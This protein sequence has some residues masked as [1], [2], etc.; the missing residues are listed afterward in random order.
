MYK[1]D[2]AINQITVAQELE[3]EGLLEKCGGAAY[4]SRLISI[5]P[6]SLDIEHYARIVYRLS[7]MR[8]LISAADKIS[9]IGYE[10]DPDVS[11]ALN[12][13]EDTLFRLRHERSLDFVHIKNV[14]D[15]YFEAPN[16]PGTAGFQAIPQVFT[17]L[18]GLDD[19]LGGFKRSELIVLAARPS[20]GKTSL[21][22][23]IAR[24]AAVAQGACVAIFSLEMFR[25]RWYR[26][27]FPVK[28]ASIPS[29]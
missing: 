28:P 17:G 22:L 23:N 19:L 15:G 24:N 29:V 7:I 16:Q 2:E 25:G 26:G 6:T 5:V 4:L 20:V 12:R 9:E 11:A 21:A 3:R 13:A 1:R 14:L 18:H 10:A 27:C 8:Q